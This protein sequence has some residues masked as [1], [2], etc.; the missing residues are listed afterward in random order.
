MSRWVLMVA[1]AFGFGVLASSGCGPSTPSSGETKPLV[2][3][4]IPKGAGKAP[5]K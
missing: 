4:R 5:E 3:D 2:G 1:L